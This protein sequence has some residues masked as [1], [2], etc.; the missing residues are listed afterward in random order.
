MMVFTAQELRSMFIWGAVGGALPTLSKLA[1]TYGANFDAPTPRILGVVI[2]IALYGVIGSIIS[3]AI[4]NPDVKQALF[5]GIAAP[6]IVVGVIS[7]ASDSQSLHGAP[8]PA[9]VSLFSPAFAQSPTAPADTA[10]R[11]ISVTIQVRG[12]YPVSGVIQI[13]AK[14]DGKLTPV[15][16]VPVTATTMQ[17][18][19]QIPS[20]P[21]TLVFTSQPDASTEV[22]IDNQSDVTVTIG[23]STS[24][25][26][27]L[28][29]ALGSQRALDIGSL[30]ATAK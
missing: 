18:T 28:K 16:S 29:W 25:T 2:A 12:N 14:T 19:A 11:R 5:A 15:A 22:Q 7:G 13:S 24:I 23:A 30:S 27:D 26:G 17:T 3:R 21:T 1:G 6:A 10:T 8:K 9:G 4:G 20:G